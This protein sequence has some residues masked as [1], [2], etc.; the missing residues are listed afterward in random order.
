[1]NESLKFKIHFR[2]TRFTKLFFISSEVMKLST[3]DLLN[4]HTQ[5]YIPTQTHTHK[6]V[7][8]CRHIVRWEYMSMI[9]PSDRKSLMNLIFRNLITLIRDFG[10]GIIE[11]SLYI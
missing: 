2:R 7:C 5:A 10:S 3:S 9:T 8:V 11:N 6:C 1:M 4:T